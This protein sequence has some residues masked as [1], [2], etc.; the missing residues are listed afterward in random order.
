M[1]YP[2]KYLVHDVGLI[3][4]RSNDLCLSIIKYNFAIF[5]FSYFNIYNQSIYK[6]GA[7]RIIAIIASI[8]KTLCSYL[9]ATWFNPFNNQQYKIII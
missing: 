6:Y 3:N 4:N 9:K 2:E 8:V 7:I 5:F 1:R